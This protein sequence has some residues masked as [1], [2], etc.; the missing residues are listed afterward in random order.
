MIGGGCSWNP[1]ITTSVTSSWRRIAYLTRCKRW[2]AQPLIGDAG[3]INHHQSRASPRKQTPY[4][5]APLPEIGQD[6][7]DGALER[8]D[9]G[10]FVQFFRQASPYIEGHRG[11]TFVVV[12]PGEVGC[13]YQS[14]PAGNIC[15]NAST[16]L[17]PC[18]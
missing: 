13:G 1:P 15:C 11:R 4:Q 17:L 9:Y 3:S 16:P 6:L 12:I 18:C 14:E 8:K 5:W 10:K 7:T 2:A